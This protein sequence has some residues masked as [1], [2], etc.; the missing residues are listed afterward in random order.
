MQDD[1]G[2][3]WQFA[4]VQP[5][6]VAHAVEQGADDEFGLGIL[7]GNAA[8]VPTSPCFR[9]PVFASCFQFLRV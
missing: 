8:H 6:A 9:Q 4:V 1:V 7:A 5:E 3:A 2:A